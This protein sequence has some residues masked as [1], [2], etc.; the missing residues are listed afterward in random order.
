VDFLER[1]PTQLY[2]AGV[3]KHKKTHLQ[4]NMKYISCHCSC[5]FFVAIV[6]KSIHRQETCA[7]FRYRRQINAAAW[8][9]NITH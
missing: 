4:P 6:I 2:P 8:T 7:Q 1:W 9:R 5:I 3:T